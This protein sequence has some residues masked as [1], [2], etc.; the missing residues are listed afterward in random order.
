VALT[1][2]DH[3]AN[4]RPRFLVDFYLE[5]FSWNCLFPFEKQI[6]F[7]KFFFFLLCLFL[8]KLHKA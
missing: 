7:T 4:T 2:G 1:F 8:N 3:I 5:S 6:S